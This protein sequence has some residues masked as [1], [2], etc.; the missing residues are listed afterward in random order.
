MNIMSSGGVFSNDTGLKKS[1]ETFKRRLDFEQ[2]ISRIS[3]RFIGAYDVDDAI[4]TSL[5]EIGKFSGVDRVYIFLLGHAK[6]TVDNTHEWCSEGVSPQIDSM[7]NLLVESF[8]W[9][10]EKLRDGEMIISP[11]ISALPI[12]A[13]KE[14]EILGAQDV[15]SLLVLPI[16][17]RR[18]LAG[19][20]GFDNTRGIGEWRDEDVS[21]LKTTSEI[22]GNALSLKRAEQELRNSEEKYRSVFENTGTA[23]IIV[24]E[25]T[26]ISLANEEFAKLSGYQREEV[27]G[28]K[29]WAE[30][31]VKEDLARMIQYHKSRRASADSA[32]RRYEFRSATFS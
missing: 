20:I 15:K 2:L 14:K 6:N 17:I 31:V 21:L 30:F 13:A 19:F 4:N 11:D 25:D 1:E 22:M 32:P 9:W 29:S 5:A 23:T 27:E 26:T 10:V 12:E 16:H 8:P 7:K 3:T 18:D 24:E 28:K